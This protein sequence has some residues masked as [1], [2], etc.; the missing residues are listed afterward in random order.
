MPPVRLALSLAAL[1]GSTV[2]S[3]L[4]AQIDRDRATAYFREAADL[5]AREAGHLLGVSLCGPMVFADPRTREIVAN[6]PTPSA[7]RPAALGFANAALRWGDKRWSVYVWQYIP[8]DDARARKTL[9][10]HELVHRIQ[11][12]IGLFLRDS[13]NDH[14]DT[15]DGRYWLQLEWRAL[16]AALRATGDARKTPLGH[17]LA[18]RTK[19]HD[20]FPSARESE[21]VLEINEGIP[22]YVATAVV[23]GRGDE[24]FAH[25]I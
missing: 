15:V 1:L 14:L 7:P 10:M 17:A 5:C 22:Q 20:M 18:F 16:A 12:D 4:A 21:R 3:K 6:E 2:G 24:A 11:P 19:R 25:A 8:A 23:S 9:L 13:S